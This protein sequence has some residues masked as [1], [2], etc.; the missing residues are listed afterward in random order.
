MPS[1]ALKKVKSATPYI[2]SAFQILGDFAPEKLQPFFVFVNEINQILED[3]EQYEEL[4]DVFYMRLTS[5]V[6]IIE[7]NQF[8]EDCA[9][10]LTRIKDFVDKVNNDLE[11]LAGKRGRL[12]KLMTKL[13]SS[14]KLSDLKK[15][16]ESFQLLDGLFP[17]MP[18]FDIRTQ[19]SD[20]KAASFWNQFIGDS[21]EC[22]YNTLKSQLGKCLHNKNE[23]LNG[24]PDL[25][26]GKF[27]R[28]VF[29]YV[30]TWLGGWDNF[31]RYITEKNPFTKEFFRM[32][33]KEIKPPVDL[34]IKKEGKDFKIKPT[35]TYCFK[36]DGSSSENISYI[37]YHKK[38]SEKTV[39]EWKVYEIEPNRTLILKLDPLK[40]HT[41][42]VFSAC[43]ARK[44]ISNEYT[45]KS[46]ILKEHKIEM[47]KP[48][49]IQMSWG[50]PDDLLNSDVPT[51][52]SPVFESVRKVSWELCKE[53]PAYDPDV[54]SMRP[55]IY[56][57]K[58]AY[59]LA[60][61]LGYFFSPEILFNLWKNP[62]NIKES[63]F[64]KKILKDYYKEEGAKDF[65]Y[66]A[67]LK[68]NSELSK[69]IQMEFPHFKW[70]PKYDEK[71]YESAS[72]KFASCS[73]K[74]KA[75]TDANCLNFSKEVGLV[76]LEYLRSKVVMNLC[77][78]GAQSSI[79]GYLASPN[80]KTLNGLKPGHIVVLNQ[81]LLGNMNTFVS[82][83]DV[84][85]ASSKALMSE[86]FRFVGEIFY[87]EIAQ[88]ISQ[89]KDLWTN[90]E[91]KCPVPS[92]FLPGQIPFSFVE[93][94]F[95]VK[96][97][98]EKVANSN[99]LIRWMISNPPK[100]KCVGSSFKTRLIVNPLINSDNGIE[101]YARGNFVLEL[102]SGRSSTPT[103]TFTVAEGKATARHVTTREHIVKS[104]E[105]ISKGMH[106]TSYVGYQVV[107]STNHVIFK[108]SGDAPFAISLE[109]KRN[110]NYYLFFC[111]NVDEL[112]IVNLHKI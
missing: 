4:L 89:E 18:S 41:F 73:D 32:A 9:K 27:T 85:T 17:R 106:G 77:K 25:V 30:V 84:E 91:A 42:K 90:P 23:G 24:E 112:D 70:V 12:E 57:T 83:V 50:S 6:R 69:Y 49:A 58:A 75:E 110:D 107:L 38:E 103:W 62:A 74:F 68:H 98:G 105:V 34:E 72:S 44:L 47:I 5:T 3:K 71:E 22:D 81:L 31:S 111:M 40:K 20:L 13:S 80:Q 59:S 86:T 95:G 26:A 96:L 7:V 97:D 94:M 35:T 79:Q 109:R 55:V 63:P 54:E 66:N 60:S 19:I 1:T 76:V 108:S 87:R 45:G 39:S 88:Y 29:D 65:V 100:T 52:K 28:M 37:V 43:K 67:V 51:N 46:V 2:L 15:D 92:V 11:K 14:N 10:G 99:A 82:K 56:V 61:K 21:S 93:T 48:R 104:G 78:A 64:A 102:K 33:S 8:N 36:E 101:F 16:I 53:N